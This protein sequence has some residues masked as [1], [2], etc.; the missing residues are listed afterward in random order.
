MDSEAPAASFVD[1]VFHHA[2]SQPTKPAII[3]PDRV[4]TYDMFAQGV[5]RVQER[6]RALNLK[7]GALVSVSI[8]SPIRTM[9]LATALFSLGHPVIVTSRPDDCIA[10]RLPVGAFLHEPGVALIPGQRQSL[11]DEAWFNREEPLLVPRPSRGFVGDDAVC[12]VALSSGTTGRSKAI[13]LTVKSFQQR[14]VNYYSVVGSGAWQRLLLLVGL[15]GGWG[16]SL[17]AHTLFAGRTLVFA[18]NPRESLHM[19]TVYGVDALAATSFQL[20]DI[21]REQMH[22]PLPCSSLRV[23]FTGGGLLSP[24]AIADARAS[25]CSSVVVQY[26]STEAGGTAFAPADR[27]SGIAGAAGFVAPWAEAEIVDEAGRALPLESDG[28]VRV[29]GTCQGA[30][31]PPGTDNPSFRDGWFY[32]GDLGRITADG[33]LIITG[34]TSEV[35]NVGGLKL[36]PEIIEDILREHPAVSDVAALGSIGED[37]IEEISIAVAVNR[38]VADRHLI[39]WCAERGIPVSRVFIVDS[40]TRTASGKIRRDL[41]KRQLLATDA[42]G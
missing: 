2:L 3:L 34:R 32:P 9:I 26:G 8:D 15:T 35:I 5:L 40:I 6:V 30:P 4:V 11:V 20:R 16:F 13:S 37:G 25:L 38:P 28:V 22:R 39:A 31:Y 10:L 42:A 17:A 12:Y 14:V 23:V 41:L 21:V 36:A 18:N 7:P 27:L 19:L 33:L 24:A 29:R 1:L